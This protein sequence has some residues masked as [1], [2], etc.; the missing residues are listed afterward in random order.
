[1]DQRRKD[2]AYHSRTEGSSVVLA[3][4]QSPDR[5]EV[6]AGQKDR[7]LSGFPHADK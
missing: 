2:I 6:R 4:E 1:M 3:Q 5:E 7:K